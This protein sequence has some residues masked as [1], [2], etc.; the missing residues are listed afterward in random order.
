[1][2]KNPDR[3]HVLLGLVSLDQPLPE[4]TKKLQ[5]FPWDSDED[6]IVLKMGDLVAILSRFLGGELTSADV[7]AWA[8][9]IESR[10]DID[11][12]EEHEGSIREAIF[13]LANPEINA[14]VT[15]DS[16]LE[17]LRRLTPAESSMGQ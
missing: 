5:S 11:F 6:L 9:A 12:E 17:M 2:N 1:M 7:V 3:T 14:P 4:I 8:N 15:T 16:A 10:E 13:Q